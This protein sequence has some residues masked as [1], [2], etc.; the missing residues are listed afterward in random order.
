MAARGENGGSDLTPSGCHSVAQASDLAGECCVGGVGQCSSEVVVL[1]RGGADGH[2][3]DWYVVGPVM[4]ECEVLDGRSEPFSGRLC[5]FDGNTWQHDGELLAAL[6]EHLVLVSAVS[7]DR[8]PANLATCI[9]R[10]A[11]RRVVSKDPSSVTP[12][13]AVTRAGISGIGSATL[14]QIAAATFPA[15]SAVVSGSRMANSSPPRRA[16]VDPDGTC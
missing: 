5:G 11:C 1:A 6:V 3:D 10:S 13:D 8:V 16:M 9:A 4:L 2:R 7:C 15:T 14:S 12:I